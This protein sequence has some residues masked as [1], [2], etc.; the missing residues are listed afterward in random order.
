[1]AV[2]RLRELVFNSELAFASNAADPSV[3]TFDTRIPAENIVLNLPKERIRDVAHQA[4]QNVEGLSHIGAQDGS[5]TLEFTT[6]LPGNNSDPASSTVTENF[7][8]TLLGYAIGGKRVAGSGST[9]SG[10]WSTASSIY[11]ASAAGWVAG[12]MVAIGT[13]GDG[14]GDGQPL[15]I[16]AVTA[17][18]GLL[19]MLTNAPAAPTTAGHTAS[20]LALIY[21]DET[22]TPTTT[23]WLAM[24]ADTGNQFHLMGSQLSQVRFATPLDGS[25]LMKITWTYRVAVW[26]R[27]ATTFPSALTMQT[28]NGFA[29]AGGDFFIN[30]FATKT[31]N[32]EKP[33]TLTFEVDLGLEPTFGTGG[34]VN[35]Q[36]VVGWARTMAKPRMTFQVPWE[37]EWQTWWETVNASI[38]RKHIRANLG[39]VGG[40]RVVFYLPY[41]HPIGMNPIVPDNVNEQTFVTLQVLGSESTD[42]S[43]ALTRSAWRLGL[44]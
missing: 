34:N 22:V 27:Q 24:N 25:G 4:R 39:C 9:I 23:R 6:N 26:R 38:A 37:T 42:T 43:S 35:D 20:R 7:V 36:V 3:N 2:F 11:L 17:A 19:D 31:H 29:P 16:S 14:K 13:K 15:V 33:S 12:D 28:A 41:A 44:G 10:A 5:A 18:S 30:D 32:T 21:P 40:Y 8:A 1:M